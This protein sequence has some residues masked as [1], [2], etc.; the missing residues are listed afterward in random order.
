MFIGLDGEMSGNDIEGGSV[1]IQIGFSV[2]SKS[3]YLRTKH[4]NLRPVNLKEMVWSKEAEGVHKITIEQVT[5]FPICYEV[6][7]EVYKWLTEAIGLS[8]GKSDNI[9]VG[10]NVSGF[11][12]PYVKKYLPKTYALFS[13]RTADLNAIC[14]ALDGFDDRSAS[15]WK[16]KSKKYAL[17]L[18]PETDTYG[19]HNAGWDAEMSILCFRYLQKVVKREEK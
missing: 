8:T 6:D 7:N 14:F 18:N 2:I 17:N 11:D 10:W 12:M 13:R 5:S 9:P 4:W 15:E 19:A 16:I 1:L 3:G